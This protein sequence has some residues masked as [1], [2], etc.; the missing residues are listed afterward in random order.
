MVRQLRSQAPVRR[1]DQG[2]LFELLVYTSVEV[3]GLVSEGLVMLNTPRPRPVESEGV[4]RTMRADLFWERG[5]KT[6]AVV[7]LYESLDDER[8]VRESLVRWEGRYIRYV[9]HEAITRADSRLRP[10]STQGE[11]PWA[12]YCEVTNLRRLSSDEEF[13]VSDL[14]TEEGRKL[15]PAFVRHGPVPIRS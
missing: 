2:G 1:L 10:P 12:I 13:R 8:P 11:D 7:D 3:E 15:S 14:T 9:A 5:V 6:G 4:Q